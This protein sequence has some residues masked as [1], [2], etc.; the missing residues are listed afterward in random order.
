MI[1]AAMRYR[2]GQCELAP[3]SHEL[4]VAG[5]PRPVEP[6]VFDLLH[7]LVKERDR[8]VSSDELIKVIW[9]GRIV[10]ES[11]INS[12]ISAARSAIGDDG[13]RQEW[14]K[15]VRGRGFR[16]IGTVTPVTLKADSAESPESATAGRQRIAFC[17]SADETRIAY[18]TIGNGY[19]LVKAGHWLTHLEHDMR[20]PIW[21]PFLDELGQ[22]FRLVRYDQRGNGLSDWNVTDFALDRFVEDLEAVVDAAGLD[23]FALYGLSQGA[24]IAIAYLCRHPD[25]VSH[26]ILQGGYEKG[27]L[28]RSE[29]EREQAEAIITLI[30]HGWGK[31]DSAFND[32][33]ATV[34]I[35]DGDREQIDSI[36]DL[37]KHST[38]AANAAA[39]RFAVDHFDVSALSAEVQVPTLVM[40]S[41]DDSVQPL[42]QA[43]QLASRIRQ[44]EFVL[45]ES[46]NHV[47]LPQ[48]P[49]WKVMFGEIERFV[50]GA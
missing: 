15:T 14:I 36:A 44:A 24:P 29:V 27:R 38:S 4:V 45:L 18:A 9:N 3:A 28:V 21:R 37:Q 40:H 17:R 10:S 8:V 31:R 5:Q 7:H 30:K 6:Q 19:P 42:E 20:N 23:R 11:A 1:E 41:R 49:A 50:L 48:E 33:I 16:F 26:L 22:R 34:Y 47:I 46:R 25:R 35:P 32:A 39:L 13:T 2:F 12:R 43:R